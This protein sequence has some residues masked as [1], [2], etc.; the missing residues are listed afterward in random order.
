MPLLLPSNALICLNPTVCRCSWWSLTS[1]AR[2]GS[3]LALVLWCPQCPSMSLN[4][5][6]ALNISCSRLDSC[7]TSP[8]ILHI[9]PVPSALLRT[10]PH[11]ALHRWCTNL[12]CSVLDS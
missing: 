1:T 11:V 9:I 6:G 7:Y 12:S 10:Q 5:S 4:A 8:P 2:S 3:G